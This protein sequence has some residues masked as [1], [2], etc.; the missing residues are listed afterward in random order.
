MAKVRNI[1]EHPLNLRMVN[2]TV[3][4]D[5]QVEVPDPLFA[6]HEWPD[7]VWEVVD[8]GKRVF[9][10]NTKTVADVLAYLDKADDDERERVLT[11]ERN[12]QARKGIL[13]EAE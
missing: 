9:D 6:E 10:P 7:T 13:G 8:S 11:V 3:E 4:P 1:S 2:Q 12:G 5:A